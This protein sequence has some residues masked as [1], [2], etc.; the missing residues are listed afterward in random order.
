MCFTTITYTVVFIAKENRLCNYQL[1]VCIVDCILC[2]TKECNLTESNT[3]FEQ[4][5]WTLQ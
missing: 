4:V 1:Y 2:V 3:H 5:Y